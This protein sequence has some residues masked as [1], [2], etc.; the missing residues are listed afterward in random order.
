MS[1]SG[2]YEEIYSTVSKKYDRAK[3]LRIV[4]EIGGTGTRDI[5][6]REA[7]QISWT[8]SWLGSGAHLYVGVSM[9]HR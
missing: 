2:F 4:L 3:D 5:L 6:N 9:N 7:R 8:R 1:I